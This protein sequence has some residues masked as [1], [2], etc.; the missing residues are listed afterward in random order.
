MLIHG[1]WGQCDVA[2]FRAA[3]AG[4]GRVHQPIDAECHGFCV[5]GCAILELDAVAQLEAP[6]LVIDLFPAFGK[7]WRD[8]AFLGLDIGQ[9]LRDI[10]VDD[11]PNVRAYGAAGFEVGGAFGQDNGD[12]AWLRGPGRP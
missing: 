7:G 2:K 12:F 4:D 10:H 9:R 1:L 6:G 5:E 3:V 8:R 11:T